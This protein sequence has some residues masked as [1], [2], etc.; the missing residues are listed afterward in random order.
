[1]SP[2]EAAALLGLNVSRAEV[3][4][5]LLLPDGQEATRRRTVANNQPGAQVLANRLQEVAGQ[6]G[7]RRLGIGLEATNYS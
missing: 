3:V 6:L 1:V 2:A 7:V 4:A 5:C